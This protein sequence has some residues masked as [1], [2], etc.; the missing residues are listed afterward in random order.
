MT[1]PEPPRH[2]QDQIHQRVLRRDATAFAEL[3]ESALPHLAQFLQEIFPSQEAHLCET[4]AIDCLLGYQQRPKQYDARKIALFA[5][6]RMAARYDLLSAI[7]KESRHAQ[8]VVSL[9][10]PDIDSLPALPSDPDTQWE[11]DEWL[12][13]QTNLSLS[14]ILARVDVELDEREKKALWLMLEGVRDSQQYAQVL[15]VE[16]LNPADQRLEVKRVK[17]RIMKKLGRLGEAIKKPS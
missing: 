2:W 3:C 16:H 10:E 13:D 5:Y 12:G 1:N 11:L 15:G 9:D 6:L 17:D 14:E 4:T 7:G 8:R